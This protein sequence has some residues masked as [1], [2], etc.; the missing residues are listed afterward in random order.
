MLIEH[1]DAVVSMRRNITLTTGMVPNKGAEAL[2]NLRSTD[3]VGGYPLAAR[4]N[5]A[6]D[7]NVPVLQPGQS[8]DLLLLAGE[9]SFDMRY[10]RALRALVKVLQ[11]AGVQV[12][13]L[14]EVEKDCG[15]L[16]RRLGDEATFQRLANENIATLS[17]YKFKRIVTP[18]P[19][20]FHCLKNE[21][22]AFGGHYQV[23]HHS[24]LLEQLLAAKAIPLKREIKAAP[25]TTYHDP[26]YLGRYNGETDAPRNVLKGIG[27]KVVEM[28]RSG[29]Q[30]RCCG[31][32]GGASFTDIPGQRRIPD[33]RMDDVRGVGAERVAV[34]CPNCTAMLEGVVG[35]RPDVVELAELVAEQ[36]AV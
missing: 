19:H 16:A 6:V 20:L 15:D 23:Q 17:Q 14:G 1:V 28:E 36:L 4:Y 29:L 32:G 34:A 33:M 13:L 18:D 11:A 22:P 7:L 21:Y 27:I 8:T 10:Q 30:G 26:C 25:K 12:A 3:T 9:G 2:D 31:W 5:W 35:D 24:Q